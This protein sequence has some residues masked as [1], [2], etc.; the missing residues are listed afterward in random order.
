MRSYLTR[1]LWILAIC[2]QA[3][4]LRAADGVQIV[5]RTTAAGV[6]RTTRIQIEP[7][8][9]RVETENTGPGQMVIF[10]GAKQVMWMID[11]SRKSYAEMTKADVDRMGS[12]M[13]GMMAEMQKQLEGMPPA[14]RAQIEA[15]MKGRGGMPGIPGA[16]ARTEYRRAGSDTVGKWACS[17]YEG[18]QNTQKVAELCTVEPQALGFTAADFAVSRQVADFFRGMMPA[19]A[20]DIFR[21]G[22]PEEQGF[23][24]VPVRRV[25]FSAGQQRSVTELVEVSRQVFPDALFT[26]PAGLQRQAMP[27]IGR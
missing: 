27:G 7:Q 21:I 10:D 13:S 9:M 19:N 18:F 14:Q 22:T 26:L 6:A 1:A 17:K 24:G 11:P 3:A 16:T 20:D 23:S 4:P 2:A 8:R 15:L 25:S 12:Q 5:E